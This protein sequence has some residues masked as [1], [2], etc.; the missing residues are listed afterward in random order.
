MSKRSIEEVSQVEE[1]EIKKEPRTFETPL[2]HDVHL[3]H[4]KHKVPFD[5]ENLIIS[6][7]KPIRQGKMADFSYRLTYANGTHKD[8]SPVKIQTPVLRSNWGFGNYKHDKSNPNCKTKLSVDARFNDPESAVLA[9]FRATEAKIA[10]EIKGRMD[11]FVAS[12][13][14][15][16]EMVDLMLNPLVKVNEKDGITYDPSISFKIQSQESDGVIAAK[17]KVFT[18]DS[19]NESFE[20]IEVTELNRGC[21]YRAVLMFEGIYVTPQSITPKIRAVQIQKISDGENTDKFSFNDGPVT[22]L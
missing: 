13:K 15:S 22:S 20:E 10:K 14:K 3:V 2:N 18:A 8:V 16:P 19:S 4:G 6:N 11:V 12:K 1:K 9:L 5:P 7:P 17:V 21:E